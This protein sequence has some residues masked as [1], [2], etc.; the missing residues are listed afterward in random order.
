VA[1]RL[2]TFHVVAFS[3]ILFR[4]PD[5]DTFWAAC[6]QFADWSRPLPEVPWQIWG[7]L[8]VG[9]AT[10]LM[11]DG[12]QR[13]LERT[14]ARTPGSLQGLTL[15]A[16]ILLFFALRPPGLAPFIYFQF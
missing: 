11:P 16:A 2:F 7:L 6:A 4:C 3:M 8:G 10:H 9:F 12:M 15:A 13:N 5:L 1:G 14:W